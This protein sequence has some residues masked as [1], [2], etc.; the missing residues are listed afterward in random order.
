MP[1]LPG[2]G[3]VAPLL[4]CDVLQPPPSC[5]RRIVLFPSGNFQ[6]C[7]NTR[8]KLS[9]YTA[10]YLECPRLD[11]QAHGWGLH[12]SFTLNL[13]NQLH[14]S[15]TFSKGPPPL[16][17]KHRDSRT[18]A[19]THSHI[20]HNHFTSVV[21][22]GTHAAAGMIA[23]MVHPAWMHS[24]RIKS[25]PRERLMSANATVHLRFEAVLRFLSLLRQGKAR[26][27]STAGRHAVPCRTQKLDTPSRQTPSTG[28]LRSFFS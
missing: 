2:I 12:T 11:K 15:S 9:Q 14:P 23:I 1:L 21:A 25:H 19:I 16:L 8:R 10:V 26:Q 28:A 27:S 22:H 4:H 18:H 17:S 5:R 6:T 24:A 20:Y 7:V 13:V 3:V